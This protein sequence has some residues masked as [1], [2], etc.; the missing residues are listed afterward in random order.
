MTLLTLFLI[1]YTHGLKI[2]MFVVLSIILSIQV[3]GLEIFQALI[4]SICGLKALFKDL[5]R[6]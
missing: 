6:L 2:P 3:H 4:M 1:Y 5:E